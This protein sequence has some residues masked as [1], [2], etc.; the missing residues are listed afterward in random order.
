MERHDILGL[1]AELRLTGMRH[2]YEFGVRRMAISI[3][4][5]AKMTTALLDRLTHHCD[6]I[7]TGNESWQ[8]PQLVVPL[9]FRS[10]LLQAPQPITLS[11]PSRSI[12][13]ATSNPKGGPRLDADPGSHFKDD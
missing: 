5:D 2:A 10:R 4:A 6:I 7:E 11:P 13:S 12:K 9:S 1:M 8:K 3:G